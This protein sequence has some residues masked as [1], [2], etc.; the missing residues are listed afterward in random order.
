MV[1][2]IIAAYNVADYVAEAVDSALAQT[3]PNTE[4]VVVDDAS[5]DGT[6]QVLT[7]YESKIKLIHLDV[8]A[9]SARARNV[10]IESAAGEFIAILDADDV[11]MPERVERMV[12]YLIDHPDMGIVSTEALHILGT[13]RTRRPFH[14]LPEF[15]FHEADQDVHIMES[16]FTGHKIMLKKELFK[17]FGGYDEQFRNCQDWELLIRIIT[18]GVKAGFIPEPLAYH[19]VRPGSVTTIPENV[20]RAQEKTL[21]AWIDKVG[22]RARKAG[23]RTLAQARWNIARA[24]SYQGKRVRKDLIRLVRT[25]PIGIKWRAAVWTFLPRKLIV[26]LHRARAEFLSSRGGHWALHDAVEALDR[27]DVSGANRHLRAAV[28]FSY[29]VKTRLNA[30]LWLLFPPAR[31]RIEHR[32]RSDPVLDR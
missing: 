5:T 30:A 12:G 29:P 23:L 6:F 4:V 13:D 11:F 27:G 16:M 25:A 3:W 28:V 14:T 31:R 26:A 1:S 8:N 32:L 9:G 17:N 21:L 2:I 24:E 22:P 19:R 7:R 10:G 18:S 15:V 20:Y